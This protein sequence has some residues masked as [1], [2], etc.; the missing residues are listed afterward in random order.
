MSELFVI[1]HKKTKCYYLY[2]SEDEKSEEDA[3]EI[4]K[5]NSNKFFAIDP[6]MKNYKIGAIDDFTLNIID[7]INKKVGEQYNQ[8]LEDDFCINIHSDKCIEILNEK[9]SK[10]KIKATPKPKPAPKTT[11]TPT[12][13]PTPKGKN[14]KILNLPES[15]ILIP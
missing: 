1:Q 14:K 7:E 10:I 12:P 6:E 15:T 13:K 2:A 4:I 9:M 3:D 5:D 8:L 11:T